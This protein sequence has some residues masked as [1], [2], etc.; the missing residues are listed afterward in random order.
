MPINKFHKTKM[1]SNGIFQMRE[2]KKK[3]E[4]NNAV[5][6]SLSIDAECICRWNLRNI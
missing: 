4:K 1:I 2:F 5:P 3:H 6:I